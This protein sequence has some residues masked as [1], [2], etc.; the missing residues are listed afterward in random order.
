MEYIVCHRQPLLTCGIKTCSKILGLDIYISI[1]DVFWCM[2]PLFHHFYVNLNLLLVSC[3]LLV[4][5]RGPDQKN[6]N[7]HVG[8]RNDTQRHW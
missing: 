8:T 6:D 3:W 7:F 5:C 4:V 1:L 2:V